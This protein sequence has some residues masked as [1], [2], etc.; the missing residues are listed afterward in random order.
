M[1]YTNK[2]EKFTKHDN[3]ATI[4]CAQ[5]SRAAHKRDH[6]QHRKLSRQYKQSV[7]YI[8]F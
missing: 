7:R 5:D 2:V 3:K 1:I 8:G 6:M 4:T